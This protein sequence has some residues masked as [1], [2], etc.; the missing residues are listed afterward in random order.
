MQHWPARPLL[1]CRVVPYP[2]TAARIRIAAGTIPRPAARRAAPD[3]IASTRRISGQHLRAPC[4]DRHSPSERRRRDPVDRPARPARP[5]SGAPA[6]AARSTSLVPA[7]WA[8]TVVARS[9]RRGFAAAA[10]RYRAS[11]AAAGAL[12]PRLARASREP[13]SRSPREAARRARAFDRYRRARAP[14]GFVTTAIAAREPRGRPQP[15][16][17]RRGAPRCGYTPQASRFRSRAHTPPHEARI[18]LRANRRT[19]RGANGSTID[20]GLVETAPNVV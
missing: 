2:L 14:R 9:P 5:P 20:R 6:T 8:A 3:R 16:P 15:D 12:E 7:G 4:P 10:A 17:I 19:R 13:A 11:P 1:G 18:R